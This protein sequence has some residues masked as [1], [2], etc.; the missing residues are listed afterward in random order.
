[1]FSSFI[2]WLISCYYQSD[3]RP[4]TTIG[5]EKSY[6]HRCLTYISYSDLNVDAPQILKA[7]SNQP[8]AVRYI[9]D[10][11]LKSVKD[12]PA[13]NE[14]DNIYIA[15][16]IQGLVQMQNIRRRRLLSHQ[17]NQVKTVFDMDNHVANQKMLRLNMIQ[18]EEL[19]PY[20]IRD[21]IIN[22]IYYI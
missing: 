17:A 12:I 19:W 5:N 4:A 10:N 16:Q 18:P 20:N 8:G 22:R 6:N 7:T 3:L 2:N 13:L 21:K 11:L 9:I 15:Y 14:L 1:M